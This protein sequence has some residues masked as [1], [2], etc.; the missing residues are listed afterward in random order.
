MPAPKY[1]AAWA[2]A[3]AYSAK[4]R[5]LVVV[6]VRRRR[7]LDHLLVAAL[8]RAV[9]FEEMDDRAMLVGEDLHL[10]MTGALDQL[11]EIDV[12]L[13]EGGLRLALCCRDVADERRPRRG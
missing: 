10:D 13:A 6:E 3:T 8:H 4:F 11:L 7:A 9:A 2:M 5:P 12:V 1:L